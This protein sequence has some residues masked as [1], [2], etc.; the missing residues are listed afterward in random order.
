MSFCLTFRHWFNNVSSQHHWKF[1]HLS[2]HLVLAQCT[3]PITVLTQTCCERSGNSLASNKHAQP[4]KTTTNKKT[5]NLFL[6][7]SSYYLS[8]KEWPQQ[9][10]C[11]H[12]GGM[13][14]RTAHSPENQAQNRTP[15]GVAQLHSET[16]LK[17]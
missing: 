11:Q 8:F 2:T 6:K 1:L 10:L 16:K 12:K 14:G 3:A 9:K 17:D 4:L 5:S 7:P 13:T 15:S